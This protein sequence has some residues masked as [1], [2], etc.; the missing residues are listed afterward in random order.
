MA[1]LVKTGT[2]DQ[3]IKLL[4]MNLIETGK[5]FF[6]NFNKATDK[7]LF[8]AVMKMYGE[9][10]DPKWQDPEYIKLK[11]SCKGD[12]S[13]IVDKLYDKTVF[14]DE[15]KFNAFVTSFSLSSVSKLNKDPFYYLQ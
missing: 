14:A 8:V 4:K 15:E 12:F 2:D 1:D 9:N 5:S 3:K 7:K 11:N 10:L 6:Q 13:S